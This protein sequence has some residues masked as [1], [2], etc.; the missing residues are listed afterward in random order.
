MMS[1]LNKQL[2]M[3]QSQFP[4]FNNDFMREYN[5]QDLSVELIQMRLK[6]GLSQEEFAEKIGLK[7]EQYCRYESGKQNMT[8][9]T[10]VEIAEISG[11]EVEIKIKKKRK[12]K[13]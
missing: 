10:L 13:N 5:L 9:L 7:S 12:S 11:Y 3:L 8:I 2:H 6:Y 4:N 1:F